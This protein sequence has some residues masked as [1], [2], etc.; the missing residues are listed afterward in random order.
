MQTVGFEDYVEPLQLYL[1]KFRE[2]EVGEGEASRGCVCGGGET[3][4]SQTVGFKRQGLAVR[5]GVG[6]AGIQSG[7]GAAGLCTVGRDRQDTVGLNVELY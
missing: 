3:T 6:E 1:A 2:A 7:L 5:C 4:G